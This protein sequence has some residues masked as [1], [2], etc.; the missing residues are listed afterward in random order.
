[1]VNDVKFYELGTIDE[2]LLEFATIVARYQNKWICCQHQDRD[3]WEVP[4]GHIEEGETAIEAAIR[5][6]QEETGAMKF[7][8]QPVCIFQI[9]RYGLLC[10]AEITELG[11][12]PPHSEI[13]KIA[14]FDDLPD[15]LTYP[16]YHPKMVAKIQETF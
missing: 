7:D 12:L 2:T 15:D 4:G 1:M 8:L 14:L 16:A 6:L 11:D 3:T 13:A 10:F 5:E 9:T